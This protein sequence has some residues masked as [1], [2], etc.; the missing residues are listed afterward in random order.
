M[1]VPALVPTGGSPPTR[2]PAAEPEAAVA[3]VA[4]EVSPSFDPTNSSIVIGIL[5]G[6]VKAV[7]QPT[8]ATLT[9]GTLR[10]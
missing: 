7:A 4:E 2:L 10:T 1:E 6:H 5:T 3:L 9:T 8:T